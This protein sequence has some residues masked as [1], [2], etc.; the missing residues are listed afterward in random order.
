MATTEMHANRNL[1]PRVLSDGTRRGIDRYFA[2]GHG[3]KPHWWDD[4]RVP[5]SGPIVG[6]YENREGSAQD[7]LVL[8]EEGLSVLRGTG[9]E[10]FEFYDV[11]RVV[12]PRKEPIAVSLYVHL[13]SGARF[14]IPVYEPVGAAFDFYRFLSS[15]VAQKR[16]EAS[17]SV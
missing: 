8:T 14:E 13:H 12:L 3:S 10:S 16:R 9:A 4:E 17:R 2:F 11:A 6:V 15:A 7:A 5:V 1:R